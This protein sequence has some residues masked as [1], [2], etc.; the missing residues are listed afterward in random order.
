MPTGEYTI[1]CLDVEVDHY[2]NPGFAATHTDPGAEPYVE[3]ICV[4]ITSSRGQR[5]DICRH[6]P[7]LVLDSIGEYFLKG[8]LAC[9]NPDV[10]HDER[11]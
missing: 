5:T 10:K 3:I 9:P 4:W 11:R 8:E 2:F 6:L 1:E 7:L